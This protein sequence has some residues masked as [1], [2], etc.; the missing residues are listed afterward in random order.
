M[1]IFTE[2]KWEA[3]PTLPGRANR[4][5]GSYWYYLPD[6]LTTLQVLISPQLSEEIA[7]VAPASWDGMNSLDGANSRSG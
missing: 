6:R 5:G 7:V 3:D 2:A 1:G 4:R